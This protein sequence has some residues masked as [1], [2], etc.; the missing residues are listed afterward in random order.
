MER[1]QSSGF[2]CIFTVAFDRSGKYIYEIGTRNRRKS[3]VKIQRNP[4]L[5]GIKIFKI[6]KNISKR[7]LLKNHTIKTLGYSPFCNIWG[8]VTK[9]TIPKLY[10]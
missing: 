1:K 2:C 8:D 7:I 3:T 9:R 4:L 5:G 6:E 10:Y